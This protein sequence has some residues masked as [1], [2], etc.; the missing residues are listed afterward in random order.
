MCLDRETLHQLCERVAA[1]RARLERQRATLD[2]LRQKLSER[3][4]RRRA[5]ETG[6][7]AEVPRAAREWVELPPL[8]ARS[9]RPA[10]PAVCSPSGDPE[11]PP[12]H[13]SG[14]D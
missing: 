7:A 5:R 3:I 4:Q 8:S 9:L 2:V 6:A 13:R 14:T 1:Q 11:H 10:G 12:P